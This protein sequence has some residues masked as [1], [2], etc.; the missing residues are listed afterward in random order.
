MRWV[1][2]AMLA[3]LPVCAA[4][5][6]KSRVPRAGLVAIE[7]SIDGKFE[8]TG[9]PDPFLLLGTTRGVYLEGFGVV[10]T[11]EVN[12]V[13]SPGLSPFKQSFT[14]DEKARL[15]GQKLERVLLLKQAMRDVLRSAA[16]SL[17]MVPPTEQIAIG[18]S[19][20]YFWWEEKDGLP[21]Q[22][23]L[24]GQRQKLAGADSANASIQTD[25]F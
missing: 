17:T 7:K 10:F 11:S 23:I 5:A 12:L 1:A 3:A 6:D 24:R 9:V 21:S 4:Q 22:I 18:V 16:T 13:N 20:F 15:R 2:C 25:E 19:L 8:H 14:A